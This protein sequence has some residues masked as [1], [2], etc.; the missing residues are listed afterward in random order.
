MGLRTARINAGLSQVDLAAKANVRK[1]TV[2]AIELGTNRPTYDVAVRLAS[3]CGL[4]VHDVFDPY[5]IWPG[6]GPSGSECRRLR[7]RRGWTQV[8]LARKA[9]VD[10][11]VVRRMERGVA[12]RP[13][14][15]EAV[16][17]A[18]GVK[19]MDLLPDD[20]LGETA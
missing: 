1:Q 17:R 16:A 20:D 9:G 11:G 7:A 18:L 10:L 19:A 14:N 8:V 6:V 4:G 3:A 13:R 12:P 5:A 2:S 15:I